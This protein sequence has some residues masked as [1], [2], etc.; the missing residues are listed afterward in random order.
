[1]TMLGVQ[2]AT[3][4]YR[5]VTKRTGNFREVD[6]IPNGLTAIFMMGMYIK[7]LDSSISSKSY[8]YLI[9]PTCCRLFNLS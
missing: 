6:E 7:P 9:G 5:P 3:L 4:D 1:M 2:G 8:G